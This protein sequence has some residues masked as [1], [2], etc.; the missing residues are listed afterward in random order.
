MVEDF[1]ALR[2]FNVYGP[3][4]ENKGNMSSVAHQAHLIMQ[5]GMGK[6]MLF[7]GN[8]KRD[9][10][11]I[12]DVVDATIYPIFN[13]VSK[14]VYEVGSGEARTF[15]DVLDLMEIPYEYRDEK[16]TP[17]GYQFFTEANVDNFMEDWKP[18]YNL[19]KGI[20]KY[21]DYLNEN[22]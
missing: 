12:E 7:P 10:V 11:Y 2:Y 19:E 5:K 18:Q 16:D 1:I 15:E 14:G 9:F 13:D 21:K 6:F 20:K 17:D 3:G 22:L 8:P 4:E